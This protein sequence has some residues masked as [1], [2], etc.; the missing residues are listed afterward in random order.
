MEEA[1]K[2]MREGSGDIETFRFFHKGQWYEWVKGENDPETEDALI[3]Y[4]KGQGF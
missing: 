3:E 1:A 4:A 2:V